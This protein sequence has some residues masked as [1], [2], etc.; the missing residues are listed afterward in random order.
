MKKTITFLLGIFACGFLAQAQLVVPA[1][2]QPAVVDGIVDADDPWGETWIDIAKAKGT[3]EHSA[4]FQIMNDAENIYIVIMVTDAT[5]NN[6]N[7][8]TY[9]RDCAEIFTSFHSPSGDVPEP[10]VTGQ[11]FQFRTGRDNFI[12][13]DL[14]ADGV[15][16]G[17]ET[18]AAGDDAGWIAEYSFP[19]EAL[20]TDTD[21]DGE[22]FRFDIQVADAKDGDRTGQLFWADD[23]DLQWQNVE[24][25]GA[26][27]LTLVSSVKQNV[28]KT[29]I[30]LTTVVKKGT[31]KFN[32]GVDV[33]SVSV[34]NSIGQVVGN[35]AN[36]ANLPKGVYIVKAKTSKGVFANRFVIQ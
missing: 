3:T 18:V 30:L 36:V 4:K 13:G 12:D 21:F 23:S 14:S 5:P 9:K 1:A 33:K 2:S 6:V 10:R 11:D 35:S 28:A 19:I 22:N 25:L 7:T 8:D 26:A 15:A 17:Y 31:I 32:P 16:T 24:M 29:N 27:K 20:A 34:H